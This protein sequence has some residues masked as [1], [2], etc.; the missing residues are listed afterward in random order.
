MPKASTDISL[1]FIMI[2][3]VNICKVEDKN[4]KHSSSPIR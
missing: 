1:A 2:K 4:H 3:Y